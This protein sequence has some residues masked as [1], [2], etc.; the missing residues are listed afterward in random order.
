MVLESRLPRL[1]SEVN[2]C[3]IYK[4]SYIH[5]YTDFIDF[6][7]DYKQIIKP[8]KLAA[9]L[10]TCDHMFNNIGYGA[11]VYIKD[12][13]IHTYQPFAN[14]YKI[15]DGSEKIKNTNIDKIIE[16]KIKY[17]DI[18]K[19]YYYHRMIK[20]REQWAF[21]RCIIFD[22]DDWWKDIELYMSIYYHMLETVLSKSK[23]NTCFFINLFD[24]PVLPKF[25]CKNYIQNINTCNKNIKIENNYI[26]VLSGASTNNHYDKCLI[27]TDVWELATQ[28]KFSK[29]C[30]S[31]YYKKGKLNT[32]WN[33]KNNKIIFRGR[34]TS[35][36]PN[37]VNKNIRLKIIKILNKLQNKQITNNTIDID[38][39]L[40]GWADATIFSNDKLQIS[41]PKELI[42]QGFDLK[43]RVSMEEQS[44]NKFILDIDGYVTPFRLCY[45]LLYNSCIV[46]VLSKYYSWF[47]D[48]LKHKENIYIIDQNSDNLE[49]DITDALIYLSEN[50]EKAKEIAANSRKLGQKI[51]NVDNMAKYMINMF[52]TAD[53]DI[54]T[55]VRNKTYKKKYVR[56]KTRRVKR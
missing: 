30:R 26:P 24:E 3:Y 19:D 9:F 20:Q 48:E 52:K 14:I 18:K 41:N 16:D 35:C 11:M 42:K 17:L 1:E 47:Y 53:F 2:D 38:V 31:W 21:S 25:K 4:F 40:S 51:I 49:K 28:K 56:N 44:N 33:K 23:I 5:G 12:G 37:D 27:Y 29:G 7:N 13:K 10:N 22:W 43:N 6:I 39:G 50:P 45:E 15:K 34:N 55:N 8:S 54:V 36:Y 46:L 32:N